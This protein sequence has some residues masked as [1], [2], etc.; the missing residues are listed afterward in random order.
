MNSPL[1]PISLS[2][3]SSQR[4]P[5][6]GHTQYV[7]RELWMGLEQ[8]VANE[9]RL[10]ECQRTLA[11]RNSDFFHRLIIDEESP[12]GLLANAFCF[13]RRAYMHRACLHPFGLAHCY[14]DH[15]FR[16]PL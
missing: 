1:P 11:G 14:L 13:R 15:F 7:Y 9:V 3:A 8:S 12:Y 2:G 16:V 5:W 4:S 6:V 10:P